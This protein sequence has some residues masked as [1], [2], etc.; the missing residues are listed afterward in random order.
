MLC[1]RKA[2]FSTPTGAEA[3]E[4]LA[5]GIGRP[6]ELA[7]EQGREIDVSSVGLLTCRPTMAEA[8]EYHRHCI[9]DDAN[10]NAV[11]SILAMKNISNETAGDPLARIHPRPV[12]DQW[13]LAARSRVVFCHLQKSS[14]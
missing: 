6:K 9:I 2:L 5:E 13:T 7:S 4:Q 10:W 14:P 3:A 8:G 11:D 1:K 12:R